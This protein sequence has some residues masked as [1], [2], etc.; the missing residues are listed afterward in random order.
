MCSLNCNNIVVNVIAN[1]YMN[2]GEYYTLTNKYGLQPT[3]SHGK[4]KAVS[5]CVFDKSV[6]AEQDCIA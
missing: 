1:N 2:T 5:Y 3:W 4:I 6:V